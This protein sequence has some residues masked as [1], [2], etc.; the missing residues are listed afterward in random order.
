M[1]NTYRILLALGIIIGIFVYTQQNP[2]DTS[3]FKVGVSV[4]L[5]GDAASLGEFFKN[6]SDMAVE[7]INSEG[8]VNGRKI[9]L[10][11]EDDSCAPAKAVSVIRKLISVEKVKTIVI[12]TCS[13]AV[14]PTVPVATENGVFLFSGIA[15]SPTLTDISPMFARTVPSD[16]SQGTALANYS[17][18]KGFKKIA[19][20]HEMTDYPVSI[21]D[22]FASV[23]TTDNG[24][25]L[26]E[27][28]AADKSDFRSILAKVKVENPDAVFFIPGSPAVADRL[29]SSFGTLDWKVPLM[30]GDIFS[31]G[32]EVVIKHKNTV[33]G[34]AIAEQKAGPDTAE[35]VAFK[36]EYKQRFG[37]DLIYESR[38]QAQYDLFFI[39]RDGFKKYGDN[40][41]E[42]AK[43]VRT[44]KN[45]P[46][47]AGGITIGENGDAVGGHAVKV[48]KDGKVEEI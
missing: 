16:T 37:K 26:T 41:V 40:P 10:I 6:I 9:S 20:I 5:T 15:T 44:V 47:F 24:M 25:L 31:G 11:Y 29:I 8:G 35:Y 7:K 46:G 42:L 4:P 18:S 32:S 43:W 14:V 48:I 2:Q 33:E 19:I 27:G 12:S 36:N 17:I 22:A 38:A 3:P 34:M 23:Y 30:G 13:G 1:K 45:Y 21:K 28:F 39:L